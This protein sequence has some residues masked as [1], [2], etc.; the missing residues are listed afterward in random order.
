MHRLNAFVSLT[1]PKFLP[2][3]VIPVV[4]SATL[5]ASRVE[6]SLSRLFWCLAGVVLLHAAGNAANDCYDYC[7][8]ADRISTA[9]RYSGGS[10]IMARR[11]LT[12]REAKVF[13]AALFGISLV[14]AAL[15]S[16]A[17]DWRPLALAVLGAGAGLFYTMPPLKLAYRGL[18][19]ITV[20]LA[21][22]PGV[23]M[24][25]YLV[26]TGTYSADVFLVSGI[27]G[28]LIGGVLLLN[29]FKDVKTDQEVGKRNLAVRIRE[30]R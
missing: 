21:F 10:G 1:R 28:A 5:A 11:L 22:G 24:G 23:M 15:L 18:G 14:I 9:G 12:V 3:S 27:V 30:L 26:L 25:T 4:L 17:R 7:L 29:E 16:S 13:F 19:E 8:G 6:I 2:L 20:A